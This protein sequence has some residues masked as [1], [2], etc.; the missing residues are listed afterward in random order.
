M[1]KQIVEEKDK[2]WDEL[3]EED[4]YLAE[5]NLVDLENPSGDLVGNSERNSREFRRI[6]DSRPFFDPIFSDFDSGSER[7][8]RSCHVRAFFIC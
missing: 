7:K 5:V 6:S 1:Q 3:M 2:G 8:R 4:K